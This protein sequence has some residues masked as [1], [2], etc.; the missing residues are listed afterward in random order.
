M[1]NRAFLIVSFLIVLMLSSCAPG[2]VFTPAITELPAQPEVL[3]TEE[4]SVPIIVETQFPVVATEVAPTETPIEEPP[5][6]VT[7][8]GNSL[9]ASAPSTFSMASGKLQLVEFFAYW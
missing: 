9:E 8:R 7:S 3:L 5:V 6:A 4:S 1:N 2:E